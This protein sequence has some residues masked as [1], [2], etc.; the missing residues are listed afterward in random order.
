MIPWLQAWGPPQRRL[1]APLSRLLLDLPFAWPRPA[2]GARTLRRRALTGQPSGK[3]S[4]VQRRKSGQP[5]SLSTMAQG[6]RVAWQRVRLG[7]STR[8]F[9]HLG[10]YTAH[11]RG[12]IT[13]QQRGAFRRPAG[14]RQCGHVAVRTPPH[15]DP[16]T[17][18]QPLFP[19]PQASL[20]AASQAITAQ[21]CWA[22]CFSTGHLG[23][24]ILCAA[25]LCRISK[26]I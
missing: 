2:Q 1:C 13:A 17:Q 15:A 19:R 24:T 7:S 6:P 4:G 16:Q 26:D 3:W 18:L 23:R 9:S 20:F 21:S 25:G 11:S 14:W 8:S 10:M 22:R 5:R 12:W